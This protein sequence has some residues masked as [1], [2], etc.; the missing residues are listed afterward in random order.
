MVATTGE[1]VEDLLGQLDRHD[2]W[3]QSSGERARRRLARARDEV[4]ALAFG[5][6]AKRLAVPDELAARVADGQC[7]PVEAAEELLTAAVIFK[8]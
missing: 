7:D 8:D 2:D 5:A 6:L 1:G 3:L 4:T